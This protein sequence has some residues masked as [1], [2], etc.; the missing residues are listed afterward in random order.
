MKTKQIGGSAVEMSV[1][2]KTWKT[3][4][5]FAHVSHRPLEIADG[6]IPT[7]PP[8]RRRSFIRI[9]EKACRNPLRHGINHVSWV[10]LLWP[11]LK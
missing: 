4:L 5:R 6:A 7:S 9:Q 8:R 2:W 3:K 1:P 10:G 11:V